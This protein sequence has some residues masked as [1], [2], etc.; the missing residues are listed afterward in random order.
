MKI[1]GLVLLGMFGVAAVILGE[2]DD[3]PGL[4]G[5]GVIAV[6]FA[7]YRLYRTWR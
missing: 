5:L 2:Q 1:A 3:S 4:Q 7:V 6:G